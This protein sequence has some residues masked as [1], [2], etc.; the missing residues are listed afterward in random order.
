[1]EIDYLIIG[2]GLAGSLL[3]WELNQRQKKVFIIDNGELNASQVAAGLINPVTGMRFV[4]STDV[5]Q[6]LPTAKNYYNQLSDYFQHTFYIEKP[7]L[8]ILR[9]NKEILACQKRLQQAEYTPY[10]S[11]TIPSSPFINASLGLL[12]QKQTGYLL[13]KAL[14]SVLKN[15]F[16]SINAYELDE[17]KYNEIELSPNIHWKGIRPKQIIFCEGH[18]ATN[19]PWFSWL[20][21]QPVK[22]EII[23][24]TATERIPQHILNYGHWFIPLDDHH[25][26][27]GATFDRT[28]INTQI[29]VNAKETLL[30]T[31]K[32]VYPSL[33]LERIINQQAGIRPT[34]LDKQAFIGHHP[35]HPELVIFNGFGA[36]GSLQI[37]W[38]S[39]RLADNLINNRAIPQACNILRY[40]HLYTQQT[41]ND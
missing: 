34:T 9:N 14:L 16:I 38:Y 7:M 28:N 18:H 36:K 5:E 37:P 11:K 41:G 39:K 17:I 23:T 10:L 6:L 33:M 31:L 24:A 30:D 13:T 20:P 19:N 12:P 2:Q 21:F 27:T 35:I 22:G 8:R 15:Y 26:R 4:K 29:T 25:F 32:Q 3:A 1:M 40:N